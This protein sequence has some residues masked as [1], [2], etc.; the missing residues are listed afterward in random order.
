M[1]GQG[2]SLCGQT[3]IEDGIVVDSTA[4]NGSNHVDERSMPRRAR[5]G[6]TSRKLRSRGPFA[7]SDADAMMLSVGGTFS[8]GGSGESG[9]RCGAQVDHVR[10]LDVVTGA[11]RR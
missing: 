6:A 5:C 4:L 11:G 2:T 8:V 9:F 7:A 10:A 3:L 1:R